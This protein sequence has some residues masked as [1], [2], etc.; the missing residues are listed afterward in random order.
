MP[1]RC[2]EVGESQEE[3]LLPFNIMLALGQL[4]TKNNFDGL[5]PSC[6]QKWFKLLSDA[7]ISPSDLSDILEVGTL[8]GSRLTPQILVHLGV[9]FPFRPVARV[10]PRD[11]GFGEDAVEYV[12]PYFLVDQQMQ[13][14]EKNFVVQLQAPVPW[15]VYFDGL[16]KLSMHPS[17]LELNLCGLFTC[18]VTTS[19]LQLC[20]QFQKSVNRLQISASK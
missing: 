12:V 18:F 4:F 6:R 15:R 14:L 3:Y 1:G 17:V 16:S 11:S 5:T 20:L 8:T 19:S 9:I 2:Q 7:R 13:P 10:T